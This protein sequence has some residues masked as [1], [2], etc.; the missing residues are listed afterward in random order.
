MT[1]RTSDSTKLL[2]V[3]Q[4]LAREGP[5]RSKPPG[6]ATLP[7]VHEACGLDVDQMY[8][9]LRSLKEAGLIEIEGE[10]PFEEIKLT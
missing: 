8:S 10:Y 1:S 5:L 9:L 7:E 4:R 3:I 6:T 2:E